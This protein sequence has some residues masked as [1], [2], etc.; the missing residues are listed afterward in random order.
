M[1]KTKNKL[2]WEEIVDLQ[3]NARKL[4][5]KNPE[6]R[7]GQAFYNVLHSR[8]PNIANK[9]TGTIIDPFYLD[10]RL[11]DCLWAISSGK[12]PEKMEI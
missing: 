1:V 7:K 5:T 11:E 2:S 12:Y 10:K 6:L 9:I 4:Q 8:Y 3:H